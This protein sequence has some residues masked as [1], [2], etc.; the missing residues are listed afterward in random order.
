MNWHWRTNKFIVGIVLAAFFSGV[1]FTG[2]ILFASGCLSPNSLKASIGSPEDAE[3]D[4]QDLS[5]SAVVEPQTI[6]NITDKTKPAVV[7]IETQIATNQDN[8]FFNDPFFR[9][10]FGDQFP[11][12]PRTRVEQGLGSGFL[13]SSD[14]YILTNEHVISGAQKIQVTLLGKDKPIAARVVG[15]DYELDLAVLKIDT[16][17]K[18]P[19]LSLGNSDKV[20]VGNWVIAIGNPYGLDHT[21]TVG[22]ISAKGRPITI[23][24]RSF[25]NLLQTDASINPGNSGGPLL[26]LNGE[27]IGINTAVNAQAQGIGFAIPSNTVKS[28]LTD[29]MNKGKVSRGWLGVTLNEVTPAVANYFSLPELKGVLITDIVEGGPAAKAGMKQYDIILQWNGAALEGNEELLQK[30]QSAGPGKKVQ[31]VVWRDQKKVELQITLGERPY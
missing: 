3:G 19:Y 4:P 23:D 12:L 30:V 11:N 2:G 28:I 26:N 20:A 8:P 1:A 17:E 10:F 18:L 22:V 24:D 31:V 13:I 15:S 9:E 25:R 6:A 21:V 7:K 29:L 5:A 27:V 14:G 16:T